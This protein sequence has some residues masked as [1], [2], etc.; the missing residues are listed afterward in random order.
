MS[1][2][3][4]KDTD[5]ETAPPRVLAD[6]PAPSAREAGSIA[7]IIE[8]AD[9]VFLRDGLAGACVD[10]IAR[11]AGVSKATLYRHF[12][13]K[14]ALFTAWL[15]EK[16]EQ[17]VDGLFDDPLPEDARPLEEVL[18]EIAARFLRVIGDDGGRALVRTA[19]AEA[20]R[21][22]AVGAAF[23]RAIVSE[24]RDQVAKVL[25][26][27]IDRGEIRPHDVRHAAG[28]FI[29]LCRAENFLE[30]VLLPDFRL[31]KAEIDRQ[32]KAAVSFFLAGLRG[33]RD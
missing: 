28:Q 9:R 7:R 11:A 20:A 5:L 12:D 29:A 18:T 31:E 6:L 27:A 16:A 3:A 25:Q 23:Y 15:L 8:G 33:Q 17:A 4:P 13:D 1:R 32:A 22:P 19:V 14:T 21:L 26:R 10:N 2:Q 30:C 24:G